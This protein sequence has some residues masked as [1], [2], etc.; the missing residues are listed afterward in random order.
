MRLKPM[1]EDLVSPMQSSFI[2]RRGTHE[3]ILILQEMVH[4]IRRSRNRDGGMII[5][6]DHEKA[7]DKVNWGFL[8]QT[9]T[10]FGFP[11][12]LIK[13][14]MCCVMSSQPRVI[15]NGETPPSLNPMCG[16]RQGDPLSLYLFVLCMERLAYLIEEE[17]DKGAWKPLRV[18]RGGPCFSHLFLAYDL[19]FMARVSFSNVNSIRRVL[20]QFSHSSGLQVNMGK[21]KVF[22]SPHLD[23]EYQQRLARSLGLVIT[24]D[25]GKYLGAPIH[26][27]RVSPSLF[28]PLIDKIQGRLSSWK[29]KLLDMATR[30]TLIHSVTSA[31]PTH[32]MHTAWLPTGTCKHLDKMNRA[33]L[34]ARDGNPR[35]MHTIKW[36]KITKDKSK[37]GLGIKETPNMNI[38]ILAK[39]GWRILIEDKAVWQGVGKCF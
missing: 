13:L 29:E 17:V 37:G 12:S 23:I 7:Y 19:I 28:R 5:K 39:I 36:D 14:I 4:S 3:N 38:A 32:L 2:P 31:M 18:C 22:F 8:R 26:H 20:Y 21:S 24:R 25:L 33:F 35:K 16:L 1:M 27:G 9:L 10:F 15:W 11:E 30:A 34:W 6:I